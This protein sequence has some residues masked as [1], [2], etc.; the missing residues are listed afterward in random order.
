MHSSG[1]DLKKRLRFMAMAGLIVAC[2]EAAA[3]AAQQTMLERMYGPY[4]PLVRELAHSM[5]QLAV[6]GLVAL[7]FQWFLPG[8][9]REAKY[10]SYEF[11]LDIV[12]WFQGLWLA[13]IS[14]FVAV[15]WLIVGISGGKGDWFPVLAT[16]P[17]WLQVLL[18][19]WGFDLAVY[20]RHRWEHRIAALWSFHAVHHTAEKVDVLTTTRLHPFELAL[21]MLFNAAIVQLGLSAAATGLGFAIY[22]YYNYYIHTNVRIRFDGFMKYV[23]VTPFMHQWHHAKDEAAMG[24]NLGVVFAWNDW[25]FGTAHH[26]QHWPAEFGLSAPPG[27]RVGQSYLRQLL[28][29]A[30]MAIARARA[31]HAARSAQM[32]VRH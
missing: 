29:P 24:R 30:Q 13:L 19:V 6:I 20:W 15:D 8:V 5:L 4:A 1:E 32:G 22:M 27:E 26:P 25:L 14:F 3:Q 16:L 10:R 12:Y 28:Y 2:A 23:L 9:R 7:P 21:A 18:A 31:W 11:W 17:F